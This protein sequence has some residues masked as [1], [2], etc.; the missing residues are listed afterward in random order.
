[1]PKKHFLLKVPMTL[2]EKL[3]KANTPGEIL[4]H[5]EQSQ[6]SS[7]PPKLR[8]T[9]S[10]KFAGEGSGS[11]S[12]YNIKEIPT[13]KLASK[14]LV[15]SGSSDRNK[16]EGI[17]EGEVAKVW[18]AEPSKKIEDYTA[19]LKK[20]R[21]AEL[22]KKKEAVK[23]IDSKTVMDL[24]RKKL[25]EKRRKQAELRNQNPKKRRE[26]HVKKSEK[27]VEAMIFAAFDKQEYYTA[28]QLEGYT[29]QPTAYLKTFLRRMCDHHKQG[30]HI[31]HYSLKS[32][33]GRN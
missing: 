3:E 9:L 26:L 25:A 16:R 10:D 6:S 14:M 4:G 5:M 20:R 8:I 31:H 2:L 19:I 33:Y 24:Q 13:S 22:E 30:P 1:M 17:L 11:S 12:V 27:E 7:G 15:Y 21:T 18:N 28:K 29:D 23:S 32:I